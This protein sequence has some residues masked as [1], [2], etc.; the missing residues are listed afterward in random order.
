MPDSDAVVLLK[1]FHVLEATWNLERN[2]KG[3][4]LLCRD[5][6]RTVLPLNGPLVPEESSILPRVMEHF[7]SECAM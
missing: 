7:G 1:L 5:Y 2:S 4:D 3:R 6:P